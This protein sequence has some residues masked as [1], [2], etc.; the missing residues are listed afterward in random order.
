MGIIRK[1]KLENEFPLFLATT[2]ECDRYYSFYIKECD[3]G[4]RRNLQPSI[5]QI[6]E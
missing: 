3:F 6:W 1:I 2:I 4:R 5:Y